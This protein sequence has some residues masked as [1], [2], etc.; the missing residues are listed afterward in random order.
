MN[1]SPNITN[2]PGSGVT[3]AV[4]VNLNRSAD[5]VRFRAPLVLP[6]Q[7][8]S[9]AELGPLRETRN[10]RLKNVSTIRS[11]AINC[12]YNLPPQMEGSISPLAEPNQQ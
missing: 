9:N 12:W 6:S 2:V 8:A 10:L 1:P 7:E 5:S 4:P 11:M 3:V